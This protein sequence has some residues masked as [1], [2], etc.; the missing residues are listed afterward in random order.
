MEKSWRVCV[1]VSIKKD[2]ISTKFDTLNDNNLQKWEK[3]EL[4]LGHDVIEATTDHDLWEYSP[5]IGC[6]YFL[7]SYIS[8]H[9]WSKLWFQSM[10]IHCEQPPQIFNMIEDLA[11]CRPL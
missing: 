8:N 1:F 5:G 9:L 2:K 7:V 4:T 3:K 11:L 10:D 6:R